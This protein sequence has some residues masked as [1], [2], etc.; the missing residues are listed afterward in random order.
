MRKTYLFVALAGF[1]LSGCMINDA[2]DVNAINATQPSGG[3]A[4]TQAL[5]TEYRALANDEAARETQYDDAGW[6]AR[7]GMAA[8]A[9]QV[10]VPED[11]AQFVGPHWHVAADRMP[12]LQAARGRLMAALDGG[13]RDRV[14][15]PAAHSQALYDCWVEEDAEQDYTS[16][17]KKDFLASESLIET[18]QTPA[19]QPAPAPAPAP[20][21]QRSYQVFFDFDQSVITAAAARVIAEAAQNAK[22]GGT[23]RIDLTG[24]T[25]AAGT[26]KYNLALSERRAAAVKAE[27]VRDG[28]TA[29]MIATKGVGKA[30]QLVPTGDGVREPQNRRVEIVL[31]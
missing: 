27:L 21:A 6:Y 4:F 25:D 29:S 1:T 19:P 2:Y 31:Q 17:C 8:G 23:S 26:V 28:I 7:K 3:T 10:V 16:T 11:P 30:G 18:V 14:P 5:L 24:H 20:V 9:G 15:G 13:A 12:D 22:S